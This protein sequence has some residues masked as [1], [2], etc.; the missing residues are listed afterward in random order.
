MSAF[1]TT[2]T[3]PPSN[4][5][6][7][8]DFCLWDGIKCD[9]TKRV[10]AITLASRSLTGSLPGTLNQLTQLKT[11][12][13]QKNSLSGDL[14]SLS[15]LTFLESVFLDSNN[16]TSIPPNFFL[17]LT[18]LQTFSISD[19]LNLAPWSIPND[20]TESTNLQ[21]FSAS[22]ANINGVIPDIFGSF[23]SLQNLRLS[24]N[25]LT[26]SL[27]NSFGGSQIQNLWLNN[28]KSPG[29]SGNLDVLSSM[30]ELNQVWLQANS[31]TGALPDLSKCV[32]L[33]DLQL[34]D[35]QLTG[36][37]PLSFY[38]LPKIANMT[39]RNNK[40]QGEFPIVG[41][42]FDVTS[43]SFCLATPG[44]CDPQVNALLDVA[45]AIGYPISLAES[46]TG[47]NACNDW[48]YVQCD[49]F[50]KNVTSVNFA[51][52]NFSGTISPSFGNL[53]SLI[54]ITLSDNNLEGPI[55]DV[56]TS[57]PNLKQIDVSNNNLSGIIPKFRNDVKF[58]FN[59]NPFL[60]QVIIPGGP[61]APPGSGPSSNSPGS[62][63]KSSGSSGTNVGIVLGVLVFFGIIIFVVYKC[64][65]KKRHQKFGRVEN[66]EIGK[67]LIKTSAATSTLNGY[68]GGFS[69]LTS[70]SS[71]DHSE[72]HGFEGGNVVI[73]I[74][75]LRQVTN[76]FSEKNILGRGGFG[77]VYKGELHDGTKIA[78]KRMESGVMG[79]KGLNEFQAEIAVLTKVRHRHLVALLGYCIN[80][81]E[82]LLVYE[83]MPQGTLTQHLFEWRE[84]KTN[85]LS[86]KQRVSIAL[87]VARGVEYLHSLAQSSFIHRD[88]K[89]SNILLGD[90]MRAK[91]ADFGLVKNAPDGKYSVETKLAGTFGYLAPEYAATGRVTTKVDVF[92]FGVVL[93]EL[94]TGR[95]ALDETM[96]DERC[97]L[98]TWFRRLLIS[99]ENMLKAIDLTLETEDEETL[100]SITKVAELAG[101]C[102]AREPF[103]RP[104]MGH[105]VNVLG[106][107]V[108]QWKP[109][110]PE[111]DDGY[112]IDLQMSLPQA[113]QRWQADEGT[114]GT[115]DV[116]F[117]HSSI[118]SK[119]SG[120][121][122]SFDSMDCR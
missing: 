55:P 6:S 24:Y 45:G 17:G 31:F 36:I 53:T 3:P 87:D 72:M 5:K 63:K 42:V 67:E 102:T 12:Q 90:D 96:P 73:S 70:Q 34:R 99:K 8:T 18:N 113:L 75:V 33:F 64:C 98:V 95:K 103:Q 93:M 115:F 58:S 39:L 23:P 118:P 1:S 74:Q 22:S 37:F 69:E 108:E 19:N 107:L 100:D 15:N 44:P 112:G 85:F 10:T 26:G 14:P 21:Q 80:G 116:S 28:Q 97:H 13:L 104:D 122:D 48:S 78:V 38:K 49:S 11:L 32:N 101:H 52:R 89:P 68:G 43:N 60:G 51:K 41:D 120:F 94:I 71:G 86:W 66:P 20:L 7:N 88:L 57:L 30:T 56:L 79:T 119:P 105:A 47:N 27:P 83:Y 84:H 46:W 59:D 77:V 121:A 114:S 4:W 109:S 91:V 35:N 61:N 40:L 54:S 29:L 117:T 106:P 50:N 76:N 92:A 9:N 111:E 25:D 81:N 65:A 110:R 82:R 2:L 16:F 62:S